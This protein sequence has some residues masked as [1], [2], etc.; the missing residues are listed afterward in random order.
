MRRLVISS[1]LICLAQRTSFQKTGESGYW[2]G[3]CWGASRTAHFIGKTNFYA[4]FSASEKQISG[5]KM[6]Y[7]FT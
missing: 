1:L 5:K 7:A 4:N 6:P 2:P 3:A